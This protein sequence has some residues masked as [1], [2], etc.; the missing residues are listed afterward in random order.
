[1]CPLLVLKVSASFAL[2]S[3][4]RPRIHSAALKPLEYLLH[5]NG[6]RPAIYPDPNTWMQGYN[7][8][9]SI[10]ILSVPQTWLQQPLI[11]AACYSDCPEIKNNYPF[12]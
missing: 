3:I 7:G 12:G 4:R 1:M 9:K 2:F 10:A 6:S 8:Y 11:V 5:T